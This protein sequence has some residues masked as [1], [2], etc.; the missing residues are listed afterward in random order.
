MI[1]IKLKNRKIIMVKIKMCQETVKITS[2]TVVSQGEEFTHSVSQSVTIM[3]IFNKMMTM[4]VVSQEE[5][6]THSVIQ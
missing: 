1:K 3:M 6:V 5:E 2:M 4:T